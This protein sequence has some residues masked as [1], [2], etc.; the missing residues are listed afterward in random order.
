MVAALSA[1]HLAAF[2]PSPMLK[3]LYVARDA[4]DA[5]RRAADVLSRRAQYVG[6][7][8]LT[9]APRVGDF[10]EDL[11]AFGALALVRALC[12]QLAPEDALRFILLRSAIEA[13]A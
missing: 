3:R 9:L 13:G 4:D 5:G 6:I 8:T 12:A 7:E 2:L 11:V 10:N 1:N